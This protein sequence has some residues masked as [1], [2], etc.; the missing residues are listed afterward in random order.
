MARIRWDDYRE[1]ALTAIRAS[2]TPTEALSKISALIGHPVTRDGLSSAYRR[3]SLGDKLP[4]LAQ[5]CSTAAPGTAEEP[6]EPGEPAAPE[7]PRCDVPRESR[8][9]DPAPPE[10]LYVRNGTGPASVFSDGDNHYGQHDPIVEA[11]KLAWLRDVRPAVHVNVGDQYDAFG[12]SRYEKPASRSLSHAST[13]MAEL[14]SAEGYWRAV[15][16]ICG[17]SHLIL[18][19]HERRMEA[20]VNANPAL[21]GLLDWSR[22]AGLP[23]TVR[24]HPYGSRVR[25]G[26]LTWEHGDRIG[27]RFGVLHSSHW[28]LANK[29]H[30]STIYGHTH[31]IESRLKTVYDE[32]LAPHTYGAWGQ[33]HGSS[34]AAAWQWCPDPNWQ[35]GFA[36]VEAYTVAGAPRFTVHQL[37]VVDGRFSW[38]G[39]VYDGRLC[40]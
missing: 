38:G 32:N 4:S 22:L 18:G 19:N 6:E 28:L 7:A 21:F 20:L 30:R 3:W 27:G 16:E 36:Y 10:S 9:P 33:G 29:G 40:M 5:L 23:A 25:I 39:K 31:R 14:R 1:A 12:L 26:A 2:R 11:A 13:L 8:P 15:S 24:V 34:V 17:E 37:A 35:H